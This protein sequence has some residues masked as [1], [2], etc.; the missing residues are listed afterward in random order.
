M[1]W[2]HTYGDCSDQLHFFPINLYLIFYW[3]HIRRLYLLPNFKF[4]LKRQC[5]LVSFSYGLKRP[6]DYNE[7]TILNMRRC[8]YLHYL[9][10]KFGLLK[11]KFRHKHKMMSGFGMFFKNWDSEKK[12]ESIYFHNSTQLIYVLLHSV[13]IDYNW[14][15]RSASL[16]IH[17]LHQ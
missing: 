13:K 17:A 12:P 1:Y 5:C 4:A 14:F 9:K 7:M 8:R 11:E 10:V 3:H 6:V 16:F 15:H 2:I